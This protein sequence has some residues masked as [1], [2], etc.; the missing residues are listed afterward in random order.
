MH[1]KPIINRIAIAS[2]IATTA[3]IAHADLIDGR[4]QIGQWDFSGGQAIDLVGNNNGTIKGDARIGTFGGRDAAG[5]LR[6]NSGDYI[7]F[8]D[9]AEYQLGDGVISIDFKQTGHWN[10][11]ETLFSKDSNGYMNGGHLT[12]NLLKGSNDHEGIVEVRLQS[13]SK[14]YYVRSGTLDLNR[15][16]NME[17]GFG[18]QGMQLE[19]DGVIADTNAYTGGLLGNTEDFSI[20]SSR[21]GAQSGSWSGMRNGY[22]G[23]ISSM[24]I[25]GAVVPAP[26]TLAL[27]AAGGFVTTRRRR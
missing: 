25:Y 15:W 24:A 9:R 6:G 22:S 8:Q 16:Y 23:Y 20:G 21:W 4:S 19:I 10:T 27:L 5:F 14:S 3:G 13:A 11:M 17:F 7:K 18:A 26:A 12:I 2:V 1:T